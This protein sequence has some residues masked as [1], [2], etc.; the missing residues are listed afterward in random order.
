MGE[1]STNVCDLCEQDGEETEAIGWYTALDG[2]DWDVCEK[3]AKDITDAGLV[4]H[5]FD[6]ED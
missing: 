2:D 5:L 1:K 6:E 4:L 3:H